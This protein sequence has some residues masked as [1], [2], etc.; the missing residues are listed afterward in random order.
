MGKISPPEPLTLEHDLSRFNSI[1]DTLNF[2]LQQRALK[3]E[4]QSSR[5]YVV[6]DKDTNKRVVGY[7]CLSTG[8]ITHKKAVGAIKR[9]MPDPIPVCVLGRLA[10]DKDYCHRG[11]GDGL[12]KEA[13][14]KTLTFSH[15]IGVRALL[16][17]DISDVAKDFY[18]KRGFKESPTNAMTL[19]LS[20]KDMQ[21]TLG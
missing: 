16:V 9:N 14:I 1:E 19:M 12:L 18:S 17:H 15:H 13:I 10:V 7:F 4:G 2:W 21:K 20:I 5:T 11:I 3:N 6:V 8:S